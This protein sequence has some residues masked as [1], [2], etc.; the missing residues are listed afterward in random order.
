MRPERQERHEAGDRDEPG[1]GHSGQSAPAGLFQALFESPSA[2]GTAID[3]KPLGASKE[4][5]FAM[6]TWNTRKFQCGEGP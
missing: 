6:D 4:E 1:L 2:S 5:I 3:P